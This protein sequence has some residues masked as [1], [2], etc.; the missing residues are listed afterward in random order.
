MGNPKPRSYGINEFS[1]SSF[2]TTVSI[3]SKYDG[4][5]RVQVPSSCPKVSHIR[6]V[7]QAVVESKSPDQ[8]LGNWLL[9]ERFSKLLTK[10]YWYCISVQTFGLF[11]NVR[12]TV[13][14]N[15][16]QTEKLHLHLTGNRN[17]KYFKKEKYGHMLSLL[18]APN[19]VG[20]DGLQGRWLTGWKFGMK[21]EQSL[22]KG[23]MICVGTSGPLTYVSWLL[24]HLK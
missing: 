5:D 1:T 12:F 22:R 23:K 21:V 7:I 4:E 19:G 8:L 11:S 20:W 24:C 14:N 2:G 16:E 13:N 18:I 6:L 3:A 9:F 15:Y 10:S 17:P